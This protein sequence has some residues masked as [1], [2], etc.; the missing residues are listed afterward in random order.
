M[1]VGIATLQADWLGGL[2]VEAHP[3]RSRL[4]NIKRRAV[5]MA[6]L[7]GGSAIVDAGYSDSDRTVVVD[8]STETEQTVES[9]RYVC[10]VYPLVLLFLPDGAY[11]A[12]PESVNALG[13]VIT[14]TYLL[15]GAATLSDD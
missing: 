13:P 7:D 15:M 3:T 2:L 11:K 9:L 12:V 6:T 14:C 8:V 5:R 10:Q 4:G 1:K